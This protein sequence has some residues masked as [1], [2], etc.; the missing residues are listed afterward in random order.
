MAL[1]ADA[2]T[3]FRV[4]GRMWRARRARGEV[5]R[6]VER[7]PFLPPE[8]TE[9]AVYFSD[10]KV[11]LYQLR[12]WY[13]P[14][15]E[16]SKTRPV[17]VIARSPGTMIALAEEC[18]LPVVY[19]RKIIDLEKFVNERDIKVM[20]YVNQNARNFQMFRYGRM[21]HVFINHG[22]SD[23]AYMTSNQFKSYDYALVAGDAA[24]ERLAKKLWGYDVAQRALPIGR[25]QADHFAGE[26]PYPADDRTV[27]LYAP[28]WEGDRTSMSY[29]SIMSHGLTIVHKI[30]ASPHHRLIYRPH[31][32]SGV[33]DREYGAA[34]REIIAAIAAANSADSQA[35][36]VYDDG[37]S[38]GWQLVAADVAITDVSAMI[39]DRLATGKPL[40]VT[41]PLSPEAE[42]DDDGYLS[43]CE[44]VESGESPAILEIV[45]RV[46]HDEEAQKRLE[47]WV[48]RYFGDTTPGVATRRFEAAI[49]ELVARWET[50]AALHMGD[51]PD[52]GSDDDDS[53]E[54]DDGMPTD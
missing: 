25:P 52:R 31:P 11:N 43:A 49:D 36:H 46:R 47:F 30:L 33:V 23:K 51:R 6:L 24:Q 16:L 20:L 35:H 8:L 54:D 13:A 7:L 10:V 9:I 29:G 18:P 45:E 14:L 28:T 37:G 41:R 50:Q 5:Q 40:L 12:Q 22:E 32:R 34:N 15:V 26:V 1:I 4:L 27:V 39:Y 3:A 53:S 17:V 2:K 42:I 38:V 19:L 21:W 48:R 44:W